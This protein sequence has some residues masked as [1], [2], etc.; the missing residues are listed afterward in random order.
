MKAIAEYKCR[1]CGSTFTY[2]VPIDTTMDKLK[3]SI[4]YNLHENNQIRLGDSVFYS[5]ECHECD[6]RM[7]G[8]GDIKRVI[9][10][11]EQ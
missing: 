1:S 3:W 8:I 7:I 11:G 4:A 6:T 2:T 5:I 10:K 9:L